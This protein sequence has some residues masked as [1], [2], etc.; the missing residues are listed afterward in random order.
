MKH[1]ASDP[2]SGTRLG[3]QLQSDLSSPKRNNNVDVSLVG[4]ALYSEGEAARVHIALDWP[5]KSLKGPYKRTKGVMGIVI[6]KD[7]NGITRFS[8]LAERTGVSNR[9]WPDWPGFRR[10][11]PLD[12]GE[13]RYET[14][15]R[16]PPG[17]YDVR[18]IV[19]DGK[20]YGRAETHVT[21]GAFDP[22]EFAISGVSLCKEVD[23]ISAY[24]SRFGSVLPGAWTVKS[25]GNYIP[26][27]SN[28]VEFKPTGN[29]RF[30]KG[31]TLYTYFEVYEPS[32]QVQPP[33]TVQ[34]Q[35]RIVDV[36]SGELRS[37]SKPI[38][39]TPYVKE[40]SPVIPIGRGI[41]IGKL[42]K[43]S[44]RL[45]IQ[46][47]DSAGKSTPWRTTNFTVE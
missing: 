6:N 39:A 26:L 32:L 12:M 45:E 27:V 23:D 42:P 5:W 46:A 8:D 9:D 18:V 31:G 37:D 30:K 44:Y 34:I 38:D 24:S 25:P 41:D 2:A 13:S 21:V 28:D 3:E 1:S 4:V 43:G 15:V 35:M 7:R 36:K 47:T 17:E 16:L 33:A 22:K 10:D 11:V 19:G 20:R 14:Q 29:T 40:G